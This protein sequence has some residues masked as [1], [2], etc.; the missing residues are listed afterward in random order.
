[1]SAG[2]TDPSVVRTPAKST[3]RQGGPSKQRQRVSISRLVIFVGIAISLLAL[4]LPPLSPDLDILL[5]SRDDD[6]T[7][8]I[9]TAHPDDEVMF[10]TPTVL[11]LV[12]AGW[13]VSALCLSTGM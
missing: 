1:M 13:N 9:L 12:H 8:L 4:L 3:A 11:A 6:R 7:A 2:V 10:F 5:D